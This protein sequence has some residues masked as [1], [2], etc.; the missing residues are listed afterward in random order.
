MG[1]ADLL[2][3]LSAP[4][5]EFFAILGQFQEEITKKCGKQDLSWFQIC[6]YTF[7]PRQCAKFSEILSNQSL[8]LTIFAT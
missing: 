1:V 8:S 6:V 5:C 4:E 7:I 3:E 2:F